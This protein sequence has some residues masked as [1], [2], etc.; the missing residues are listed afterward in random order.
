MI[1]NI[2][3]VWKSFFIGIF[4]GIGICTYVIEKGLWGSI[5]LV[6]FYPIVMCSLPLILYLPDAFIQIMKGIRQ[7][8]A[9][10]K[11]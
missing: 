11:S 1:K 8:N 9:V 6:L 3:I 7:V 5:S 2:V 4:I 10:R